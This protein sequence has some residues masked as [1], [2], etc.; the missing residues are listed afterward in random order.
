LPSDILSR[1]IAIVS[2]SP[3]EVYRKSEKEIEVPFDEINVGYSKENVNR[4]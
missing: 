3:R 2:H 4:I 1:D